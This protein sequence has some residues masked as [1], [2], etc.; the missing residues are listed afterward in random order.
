M[1]NLDHVPC[2]KGMDHRPAGWFDFRCGLLHFHAGDAFDF[3]P[4]SFGG[5]GKKL[6]VIFLDE[7][8]SSGSLGHDL[9]S[10]RQCPVQS[11]HQGV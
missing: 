9:L 6:T 10:W 11:D 8:S 7:G 2:G 5:P 1:E 3:P 4:E